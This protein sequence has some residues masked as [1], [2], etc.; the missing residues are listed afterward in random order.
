MM[1]K[2]NHAPYKIKDKLSSSLLKDIQI[3][4]FI[5]KLYFLFLKNILHFININKHFDNEE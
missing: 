2:V 1:D 5:F 3:T 4:F